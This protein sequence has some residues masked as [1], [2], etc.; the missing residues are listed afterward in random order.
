MANENVMYA[1]MYMYVR[2]VQ[3][4]QGRLL[5]RL[6]QPEE[7]LASGFSISCKTFCSSTYMYTLGL[8]MHKDAQSTLFDLTKS[9]MQDSVPNVNKPYIL[10]DISVTLM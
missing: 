5:T 2:L 8:L 6:E 4:P 9:F 7:I 1:C 10:V 3:R